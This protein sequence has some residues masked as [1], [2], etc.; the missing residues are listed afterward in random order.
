[1]RDMKRDVGQ[2]G[3]RNRLVAIVAAAITFFAVLI[4]GVPGIDPSLWDEAAVVAGVRPPYDIFP[5]FW[6][7]LVGGLFAIIGTKAS[8]AILPFLGAVIAAVCSY[9]VCLIT[10]QILALLVRTAKPYPVWYKRI[11]PFFSFVAAVLFGISDP[12]FRVAQVFSPDELRLVMF[13]VIIHLGLRWFVVGGRWR[14]FP[15]M[16]LMG[17]LAAETPFGFVLPLAFIGSYTAVWFCI[18]DN[19]FSN[20]IESHQP[21][22]SSIGVNPSRIIAQFDILVSDLQIIPFWRPYNST[23]VRSSMEKPFTCFCRFVAN[24]SNKLPFIR[25]NCRSFIFQFG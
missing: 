2:V 23:F 1:M 21:N 9:L 5:G 20:A 13:L 14:L 8:V 25:F 15:L 4:W 10:R 19:L 18:M 24:P 16:A 12:L 17:L 3:N 7:V 22:T 11:A 6:R